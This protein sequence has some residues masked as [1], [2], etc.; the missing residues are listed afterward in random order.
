MTRFLAG[1]LSV[2]ALGL[3]LIAY[4][5]LSPRASAF[6]AG[7]ETTDPYGR[8]M[9]AGDRLVLPDDPNAVRYAYANG[10]RPSASPSA[11]YGYP[12]YYPSPQSAQAVAVPVRSVQ[13]VVETPAPRRVVTQAVERGPRRDWTKTALVIGGSTAAGA[14][15]GGIIGGKKGALIGAAIGGGAS[16]LYESTK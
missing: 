1:I 10:Y 13:T 14:G 11:P 12:A 15:V 8:A 3:L 4:G 2:I 9:L 16:T 6:S 5:L 7:P